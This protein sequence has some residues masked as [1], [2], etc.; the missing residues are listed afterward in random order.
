MSS[1]YAASK[2]LDV[3][4]IQYVNVQILN[5]YNAKEIFLC[6]EHTFFCK[7]HKIFVYSL[8]IFLCVEHTFLCKMHKMLNV[9]TFFCKLHGNIHFCVTD[10]HF[11]TKQRKVVYFC[12]DGIQICASQ[13]RWDYSFATCI[14][15]CT[16]QSRMRNAFYENVWITTHNIDKSGECILQHFT[17]W[18]LL[19]ALT[20]G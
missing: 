16:S 3:K 18:C 13:S 6:V 19:G 14:Q 1:T 7:M 2:I 5:E 8:K 11:I 20:V 17:L 4:N 15:I 10:S 9:H 12:A